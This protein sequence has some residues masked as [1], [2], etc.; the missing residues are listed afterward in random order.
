MMRVPGRIAAVC[1]LLLTHGLLRADQ[2]SV[3]KDV[4]VATQGENCKVSFAFSGDVRFSTEQGKGMVR[5]VFSRVRPATAGTVLRRSVPTG[6]VVSISFARPAPDS[7]VATLVL[8]EGSTY[9]CVRPSAGNELFV[10]V[11]GRPGVRQAP[12]RNA[13]AVTGSV[14]A[15]MKATAPT[16]AASAAAGAKVSTHTGVVSGVARAKKDSPAR[17]TAATH[18]TGTPRDDRAAYASTSALIDIP[19]VAREQVEQDGRAEAQRSSAA[20]DPL[21]EPESSKALALLLSAGLS[22]FSTVMTI[23]VWYKMR[24]RIADRRP[25]QSVEPMAGEITR[26]F[27]HREPIDTR[28]EPDET[29]D[30]GKKELLAALMQD[31]MQEDDGGRE[32]SLQLARTFKRGSEEITLARRFHEQG[33][34]AVSSERM[35]SALSRA[36]TKTQ[37]LQAARK[38]G[39]GRGEFDLALKLKTM[40]HVQGKKEEEQ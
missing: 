32:T 22:L 24:Q 18:A 38:L 20:S 35:Q 15:T 10:D 34:V 8:A 30:A 21:S 31:E 28:D 27:A 25:V 12:M 13:A 4:R 29:D 5:L 40:A 14:P 3:L 2:T 16:G 37:R 11:S 23:G 33:T 36:T 39:V 19:A 7:L 26:P 17:G 9:R 1:V 6:P